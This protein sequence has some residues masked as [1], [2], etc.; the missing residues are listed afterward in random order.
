MRRDSS[1]R[2]LA[3]IAGKLDGGGIVRSPGFSRPAPEGLRA[4]GNAPR[5]ASVRPRTVQY[6]AMALVRGF[7]AGL[8]RRECEAGPRPVPGRSAQERKL[9]LSISSGCLGAESRARHSGTEEGGVKRCNGTPA[10]DRTRDPLLRRQMLYPTELRARPFASRPRRLGRTGRSVRARLPARS[11]P[12]PP[13]SI[14]PTLP[15]PP[16]PGQARAALKCLQARTAPRA[17]A[18]ASARRS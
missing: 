15:H 8:W 12:A 14:A 6:R 7:S 9:G 5:A 11:N 17:S 13:R 16:R 4:P 3:R 10:A 18:K 1:S 2:A